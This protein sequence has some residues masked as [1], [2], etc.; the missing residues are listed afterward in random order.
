MY[1]IPRYNYL[2]RSSLVNRHKLWEEPVDR[3]REHRDRIIQE[4]KQLGVSWVGLATMES[5]YLPKIIHPEEHIKGIVYGKHK[6]G[7]AM[8][9]ATDLRA[10]FLD[11]KP[12]FTNEDEITYYV[13]SGVNFG[14]AG[15]YATVTLHTRV[16][17]YSIRTLNRKCARGFV[18]YIE[19]H[20]L[21]HASGKGNYDQLT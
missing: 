12:L 1:T 8:L 5:R 21:E 7:F 20:C 11:K 18:E 16:K 2:R 10:I 17:D 13:V 19:T 3:V 6:D 15:L 14:Q 4:L 9:V